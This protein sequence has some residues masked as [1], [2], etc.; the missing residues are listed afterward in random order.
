M[1]EPL[2]ISDKMKE[3]RQEKISRAVERQNA[4]ISRAI[5]NGKTETCFELDKSDALYSDVR[6][7]FEKAG[8][9]IK[10]TGYIGGVWQLTEDICW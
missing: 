2:K 10:P 3:S 1:T 5:G 7:I 6:N 9:T 4:I 8:Y